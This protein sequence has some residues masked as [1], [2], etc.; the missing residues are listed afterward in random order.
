MFSMIG[1]TLKECVKMRTYP[2]LFN[3]NKNLSISEI[4][5]HSNHLASYALLSFKW[6]AFRLLKNNNLNIPNF[7]KSKLLRDCS[8]FSF[9]LFFMGICS[10]LLFSF[11]FPVMYV[12]P[13]F[14]LISSLFGIGI[15]SLWHNFFTVH[16]D[17]EISQSSLLKK[18]VEKKL[19]EYAYDNNIHYSFFEKLRST[20]YT[21]GMIEDLDKTKKP[22]TFIKSKHALYTRNILQKDKKLQQ[23][24][25]MATKKQIKISRHRFLLILIPVTL[26]LGNVLL[27]FHS[28]TTGLISFFIFV[29]T[30]VSA[31]GL[32]EWQK[33][34]RECKDICLLHEFENN[35]EFKN[36]FFAQFES[37]SLKDQITT[38]T[39]AVVRKVNRL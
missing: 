14:L 38:T 6:R 32:F 19:C 2:N 21:L 13:C 25:A 1:K 23:M 4:E 29:L 24:F 17:F 30:A 31:F 7:E 16:L 9:I 26:F 12:L 22:Y 11:I 27:S 15:I 8:F 34:R 3:L 36:E 35:P 10:C 33:I 20:P 28:N 37:D 5:T 39:T 18:Y